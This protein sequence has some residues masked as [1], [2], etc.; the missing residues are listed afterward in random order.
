MKAKKEITIFCILGFLYLNIEI[1]ARAG[2]QE[3]TGLVLMSPMPLQ[4]LSLAGW[5]SIWMFFI[6]G[7]AG[8]FAGFIDTLR[9]FAGRKLWLKMLVCGAAI[10]ATELLS[11]LL[12]NSWL[13]LALWDYRHSRYHLYG[14]ISVRSAT[15]FTTMAPF[16]LW[17][18]NL[19]RHRLF[20]EP[21]R[22]RFP[23]I[24]R[25]LVLGK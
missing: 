5:T 11:G 25:D 13:E 21:K 6:G 15:A 1:F 24:Y 18:N 2:R 16:V 14:Q 7:F 10:T 22:Y 20:D 8:W 9:W 19:L 17:L 3:L 23:A 4:P 12:L